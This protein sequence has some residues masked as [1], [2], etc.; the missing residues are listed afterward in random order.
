MRTRL[1]VSGNDINRKSNFKPVRCDLQIRH[2]N[3]EGFDMDHLQIPKST[4]DIDPAT[5]IDID[6]QPHQME[7]PA[8]ATDIDQMEDP[9][10]TTLDI[11]F[12]LPQMEDVKCVEEFLM[13]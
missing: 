2:F 6:F 10:T 9:T 11:D 12:Q 8:A 1:F 5:T 4:V 7:D 13:C 3:L